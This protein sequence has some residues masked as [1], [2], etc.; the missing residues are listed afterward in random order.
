M[1]SYSLENSLHD[2]YFWILLKAA[3]QNPLQPVRSEEM[4][5]MI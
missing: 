1:L 2:A 4:P 3:A 5:W